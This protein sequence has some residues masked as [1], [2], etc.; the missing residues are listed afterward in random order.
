MLDRHA[1]SIEVALPHVVIDASVDRAR[2]DDSDPHTRPAKHRRDLV[3]RIETSIHV[4]QD[5]TQAGTVP[6]VLG[7]LMPLHDLSP[8]FLDSRIGEIVDGNAS[9]ARDVEGDA[10]A[11]GFAGGWRPADDTLGGAGEV[12]AE[13]LTHI[14]RS[15]PPLLV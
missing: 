8:S 6:G 15:E 2:A 5:N 9:S 1:H 7:L 11:F 10:R 3:C 4:T 12:R 13:H 14:A